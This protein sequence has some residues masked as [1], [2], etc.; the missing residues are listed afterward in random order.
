MNKIVL[1]LIVI[2]SCHSL[3]SGSDKPVEIRTFDNPYS[4]NLEDVDYSN[5]AATL[6]YISSLHNFSNYILLQSIVP[7]LNID[8]NNLENIL[9]SRN[10]VVKNDVVMYREDLLSHVNNLEESDIGEYLSYDAI[11]HNFDYK[12]SQFPVILSAD[13]YDIENNIAA[14]EFALSDLGK[15]VLTKDDLY[16]DKVKSEL[17]LKDEIYSSTSLLNSVD[18]S[19]YAQHLIRYGIYNYHLSN[20]H[21]SIEYLLLAVQYLSKDEY[22]KRHVWQIYVAIALI[23]HEIKAISEFKSSLLKAVSNAEQYQKQLFHESR[24]REFSQ[25]TIAHE[26]LLE[27]QLVNLSPDDRLVI[28]ENAKSSLLIDNY[29]VNSKSINEDI[30]SEHHLNKAVEL[31]DAS[32]ELMNMRSRYYSSVSKISSENNTH[33]IRNLVSILDNYEQDIQ[34]L[35]LKTNYMYEEFTSDIRREQYR[36]Q[37]LDAE[38]SLEFDLSKNRIN[39]ALL[40]SYLDDKTSVVYYFMSANKLH[41]WILSNEGVK[42]YETVDVNYVEMSDNIELFRGMIQS[43]SEIYQL[44]NELYNILLKPVIHL[45]S[46]DTRL[47]IVPHQYLHYL[48]FDALYQK[49]KYLIEEYEIL[50]LPKLSFVENIK[51]RHVNNSNS[52]FG[53]AGLDNELPHTRNEILAT[54]N[55]FDSSDVLIGTD[56]NKEKLYALDSYDYVHFATHGYSISQFPLLSYLQINDAPLFS[57]EIEKLKMN[58]SLVVLSACETSMGPLFRSDDIGSLSRAFLRNNVSSVIETLWRV[59]DVASMELIRFFFKNHIVDNNIKSESLKNAK[60][61]L[62]NEAYT[63][64]Y[65]GKTIKFDHPYYWSPFKLSGNWR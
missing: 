14:I 15:W 60:L 1:L 28:A 24:V 32:I 43:K 25:S 23:S 9:V 47:C 64:D 18:Y 65:A 10:I 16:L 44:G 7:H 55:Y 8:D 22:F 54:N 49:G 17:L 45:L 5:S 62:L 51:D 40:D 41:I 61:Y 21:K 4:N 52:Y 50:Y 57:Y 36:R 12:Y 63:L 42:V 2:H 35:S 58:A 33:A 27:Q 11:N 19:S 39:Y 20:Y 38:E 46:E 30:F 37:V 59:D 3:N 29:Q 31:K 56:A 34:L 26:I 13:Q 6:Y 48:P 53:V